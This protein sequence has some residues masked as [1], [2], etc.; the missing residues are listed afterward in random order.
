MADEKVEVKYELNIDDYIK[1]LNLLQKETKETANTTVESN[2]KASSSF[3]KLTFVMNNV[4]NSFNNIWGYVKNIAG[5][6]MGAANATNEYK[7]S[8]TGLLKVSEAMGQD[9]GAAQKA[10]EEIVM[11]AKGMVTAT[12]AAQ[13]LKLLISAGFTTDQASEMSK[14]ILNTA[15]FNRITENLGDAFV[16]AAKGLKTG[17]VELTENAGFTETSTRML[18]RLN[19]ETKNGIDITNNATQRMGIYNGYM[20][21]GAL[22]SGNLAEATKGYS[23]TLAE[24]KLQMGSLYRML[25]ENLQPIITIVAK[26]MSALL[27]DV[28]EFLKKG[29]EAKAITEGKGNELSITSLKAQLAENEKNIA[30]EQASKTVVLLGKS[31]A[32]KIFE[33]QSA[34]LKIQEELDK[35]AIAEEEQR[36]KSKKAKEEATIEA[37]KT[38]KNEKSKKE[39]AEVSKQ[40]EIEKENILE[41]ISKNEKEIASKTNALKI[42]LAKEEEPF[43]RQE[44]INKFMFEKDLLIEESRLMLKLKDDLAKAKNEEDIARIK[45]AS[46]AELQAFT[47]NLTK[48]YTIKVSKLS[49]SEKVYK[50]SLEKDKKDARNDD[51]EEK[52]KSGYDRLEK[53]GEEAALER[54]LKKENLQNEKD[55]NFE[56]ER[57][58]IDAAI[59]RD[60]LRIDN[61]AKEKQKSDKDRVIATKDIA[62]KRMTADIEEQILTGKTENI[63]EFINVLAEQLKATLTNIAIESGIQSLF[64]LAKGFAFS[65]EGKA[66]DAS[67]EFAASATFATTAAAAGMGAVAAGAAANGTASSS[68]ETPTNSDVTS[69]TNK[70]KESIKEPEVIY[71]SES[72][73]KKLSFGMVDSINKAL[74]E[75]KLL[76]RAR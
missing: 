53:L 22:F 72:D 61:V 52:R 18:T 73:M 41:T 54:E 65:A 33:L 69:T 9:G 58:G 7:M 40:N 62:Y 46:D 71:I 66:D 4:T 39:L 45:K 13:G 43:K 27:K 67:K 44:M 19:I 25:G 8:M 29:K 23:A 1:Y 36:K 26:S 51:E 12:Q 6:M 57:L 20:Q 37:E 11:M 21:Q 34:N 14:A 17:S 15:A 63:G 10:S 28:N 68:N 64:S 70:V 49:Q 47:D 60:K 59:E 24:T 50:E 75:G 38:D 35:R 16:D 2:K 5:F 32:Q 56:L 48:E 42:D 76:G 31:H 55:Y 74:G 30:A 3:E